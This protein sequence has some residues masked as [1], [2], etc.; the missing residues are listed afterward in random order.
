MLNQYYSLTEVKSAA[1]KALAV[2][3]VNRWNR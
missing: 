2:E 1:L 3:S